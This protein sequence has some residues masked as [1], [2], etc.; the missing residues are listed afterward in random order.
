MTSQ[1]ISR[2]SFLIFAVGLLIIGAAWYS[3]KDISGMEALGSGVLMALAFWLLILPS[4]LV[5]VIAFCLIPK[6]RKFK[7]LVMLVI[8]SSFYGILGII[9]LIAELAS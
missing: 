2:I 3:G 8:T 6:P 4:S 9:I 1:K 5:F 7:D